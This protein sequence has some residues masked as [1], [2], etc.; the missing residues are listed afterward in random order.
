MAIGNWKRL[1]SN[2]MNL[3][4]LIVG[5][6]AVA[7]GLLI[8]TQVNAQSEKQSEKQSDVRLDAGGKV[9]IFDLENDAH[10]TALQAR[11][12][13]VDREPNQYLGHPTTC[14][15]EDNQTILCVYPQGHGRGPIVYKKSMD[16]G[17]TWSNRLP[18]PENWKTSKET[19]TL[20][21]VIGPDGKRRVIMFS[22]LYPI[23][24]AVSEDDGSNWSELRK[25]GDFGGIVS[26]SSVFKLKTG[27]GHYAAMFHDDG[28]FADQNSKR[29]KPV[30]FSLFLTRSTD[31][32][33]S[34]ST[35]QTVQTSNQVHL[36]EPGI[37]RSPDGKQL[38]CML[39]ENSRKQPSK[40]I[41]SDDEGKTWSQPR[42]LCRFLYGDRHTAQYLPDGRLFVSLRCNW[43]RANN[44]H[45]FQGDWVAWLGSYQ[46]LLDGGDGQA[47][48]RL[49]D[50]TKAADCAY[51]GVEILP[52]GTIV[53]TTYGHWEKG[54]PPF[55]LSVRLK[56]GLA[57]RIGK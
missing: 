38:A 36:C 11:F 3:C 54:L 30:R 39:R 4:Q 22:G 33:L 6:V 21:R 47:F 17:R 41:F 29:E 24:M 34:W 14:L 18:T 2:R 15:L 8:C 46:D 52:D 48:I 16:A 9:R 32:G 40:V 50:N 56:P 42:D 13:T 51:P 57:C 25:I 12:V 44:K 53:T 35:P 20:H 31:G 26:M 49:Q 23:R 43:P 5:S 55:I 19:P 10:A 1:T 28:R 37:I 45:E 27:A 7:M